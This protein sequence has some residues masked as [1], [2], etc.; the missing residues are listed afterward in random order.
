MTVINMEIIVVHAGFP[1]RN[2]KNGNPL[3]YKLDEIQEEGLAL[4]QQITWNDPAQ[5]TGEGRGVFTKI[6]KNLFIILS[7][8]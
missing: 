3:P 2:D 6:M 7:R 5:R 8:I 4:L 1:I